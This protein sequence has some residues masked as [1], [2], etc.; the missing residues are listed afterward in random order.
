MWRSAYVELARLAL[1]DVLVNA[2]MNEKNLD[3]FTIYELAEVPP[4][5]LD[6]T[7][8]KAV[9]TDFQKLASVASFQK[10]SPLTRSL[11]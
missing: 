3:Y 2:M 7:L 10:V 5:L 9:G 1:N 4:A 8:L 6:G 11:A